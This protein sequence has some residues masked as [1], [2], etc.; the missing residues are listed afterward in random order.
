MDMTSSINAG[1]LRIKCTKI[2]TGIN[3]TIK[4]SYPCNKNLT[5][6]KHADI[7][8]ERICMTCI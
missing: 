6:I 3:N 8:E 5:F 7:L 1:I 4:M 2:K